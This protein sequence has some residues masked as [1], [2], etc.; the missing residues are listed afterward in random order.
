M[1]YHFKNALK[2]RWQYLQGSL[3]EC[4]LATDDSLTPE[5]KLQN[6]LDIRPSIDM[7]MDIT[8]KCNI[9]CIM[10]HH[11]DDKVHYQKAK[12]ITLEEFQHLFDD[13][14]PNLRGVRLSCGHE[15]LMSPYFCDIV[16]YI[17]E[18][19]PHVDIDFCTNAMLMNAK[20]RRLLIEK[21][22]AC[23][24]VSIDGVS[25]KTFESI[26][27]GAKYESVIANI[28]ALRDLKRQYNCNYP[29]L[30]ID[31]VMMN[32]N[33][34]EA[35]LLIELCSTLDIHSV[36]FRH[37]VPGNYFNNQTE[38]LSNH[39]SKF[40]YFRGK[41]I[42]KADKYHI[43]IKIPDAFSCS[44][45]WEP[46]SV[47]EQDLSEFREVLP[48]DQKGQEPIVDNTVKRKV[49]LPPLTLFLRLAFSGT[50]CPV[51]APFRQIMVVDQN[52]VTPCPYY[53][54]PLAKLADG[55]RLSEIFFGDE[56]RKVRENM[57][58]PDGDPN[59]CG[60]PVKREFIT[61]DNRSPGIMN[62][63]KRLAV[64]ALLVIARPFARLI[65]KLVPVV[66]STHTSSSNA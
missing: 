52:L 42:E 64:E 40:N 26:R 37:V 12:T 18:K 66:R 16:S 1:T 17:A 59:C 30:I 56:F 51:Y 32:S 62:S 36:D 61:I 39:R 63:L 3:R 43:T 10:C 19:H 41:I 34:H 50:Y 44:E 55:C 2:T 57:F 47:S 9:R 5:Q 28:L 20:V 31:F 22:V 33:I 48:D 4:L 58:Q 60:C 14:G 38:M 21:R 65:Q 35:P 53:N 54:V 49:K 13:L 23:V 6:N 8:N 25:K 29:H 45:K 46:E 24:I 27:V 11:I 7:C 15:P